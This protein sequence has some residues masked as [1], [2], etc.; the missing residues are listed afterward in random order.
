MLVFVI[1]TFWL[2]RQLNREPTVRMAERTSRISHVMFHL[3]LFWPF[4]VTAWLA[5]VRLEEP[6]GLP[7]LPRP[8]MAFAVGAV[9]F[10][11][12]V[13]LALLCFKELG[14]RGRGAPSFLLAKEIVT[15][16]LY[17]LSRNP[18]A[19]GWY[20]FCLGASLLAGST[21]LT[22]E[23]LLLLVPAHLFYLKHFEEFEL[24]IRFGDAYRQYRKFVP[25]LLPRFGPRPNATRSDTWDARARRRL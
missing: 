24:E 6:L 17:Q 19:L 5:C 14:L 2:R 21:Y 25:F 7:P 23:T 4:F 18:L 15:N 9:L 8:Q 12:G 11:T 13:S 20:L 22:L 1:G 16:G 10:S 3:G